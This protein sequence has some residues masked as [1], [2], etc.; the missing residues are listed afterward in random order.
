MLV[1]HESHTRSVFMCSMFCA[2]HTRTVPSRPLVKRRSPLGRSRIPS[3]MSRWC[4]C[5]GFG[6]TRGSLSC[7]RSVKERSE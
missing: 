4:R 3:I 7:S 5:F 2:F 6:S 1:T